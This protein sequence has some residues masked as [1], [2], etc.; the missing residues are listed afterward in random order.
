MSIQGELWT[1]DWIAEADEQAAA[2]LHREPV[3]PM[4]EHG[5]SC[6]RADIPHHRAVDDVLETL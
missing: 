6:S 3:W 5:R 1:D 4:A 2:D